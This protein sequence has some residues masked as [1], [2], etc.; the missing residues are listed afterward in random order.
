MDEPGPTPHSKVT[1]KVSFYSPSLIYSTSAFQ[2][3]L[4]WVARVVPDHTAND[5]SGILRYS[6][7]RTTKYKWS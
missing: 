6:L 5:I 7:L 1:V 2:V 3:G 4:V